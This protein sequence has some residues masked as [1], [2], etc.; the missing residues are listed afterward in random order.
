MSVLLLLAMLAVGAVLGFIF[1]KYQALA[2][3]GRHLAHVS[4][5]GLL[6]AMGAK[7]AQ[8][9]SLF[10]DDLA[11]LFVA[12]GSAA[13]LTVVFALVFWLVGGRKKWPAE[14]SQLEKSEGPTGK[15][16]EL[17]SVAANGGCIIIGFAV[18]LL[19]PQ[20]SVENYPLE[21]IIDWLLMA[22]LFFVG[23]GLGRELK[24]LNCGLLP[25]MLLL[26]PFIN[27]AISLAFGYLFGFLFGLGARQ[28][29]LLTAGMGWYSLSSVLLAERGLVVLSVLAFIH[30]VFRELFAI[31]LAP[32]AAKISPLLPIYL[33]G[34]TSGDV[35]LPFVQ[36]YCGEEYTLVSFYSGIVCSIAVMPL[37]KALAG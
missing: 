6:V 26:V 29:A 36:K 3:L 9:R 30:N 23:F 19:L 28:G 20:A 35:M 27:M 7:L 18:L 33:G 25:P 21:P 16:R 12:I 22:L 24:S 11:V 34:A 15:L 1:R 8:N 10:V 14:E 2:G 4:I 31:L 13:A 5:W 37:V 17:F 32:I